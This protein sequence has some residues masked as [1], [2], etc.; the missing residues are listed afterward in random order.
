MLH[1]Q[2]FQELEI[3]ADPLRHTLNHVII[4]YFIYVVANVHALAV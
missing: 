2:K 1:R 3:N 4:F